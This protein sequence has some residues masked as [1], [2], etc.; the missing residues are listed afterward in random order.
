MSKSV[1]LPVSRVDELAQE[2]VELMHKAETAGIDSATL[3]QYAIEKR[4][5]E[6]SPPL[7]PILDQLVQKSGWMKKAC[8]GA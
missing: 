5:Q 3:L 1:E 8:S 6:D 4:E 7:A 2:I